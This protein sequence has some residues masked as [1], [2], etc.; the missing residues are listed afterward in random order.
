MKHGFIGNG[1]SNKPN[2]F[3]VICGGQ[4]SNDGMKPSKLL[5]HLKSKHS[6]L[7]DKP[8]EFFEIKKR[9]YEGQKKI[10]KITTT[11][12]ESALKASFLV[13][14]RIAKAK[15]PFTIGEELICHRLK[16]FVVKY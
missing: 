3:G 1:D 7:L 9:E 5:S 14:R 4:L 6:G 12:N 16:I 10:M 15:K 8:L 13:A 2:P 11:V